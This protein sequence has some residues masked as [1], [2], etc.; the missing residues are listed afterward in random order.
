MFIL[1]AVDRTNVWHHVTEEACWPEEIYSDDLVFTKGT[2]TSV[3]RFSASY[4]DPR[5]SA[6]DPH[7]HAN[8]EGF[9]LEDK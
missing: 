9:A 3:I 4:N 7:K 1:E 2:R 5:S 6:S 8:H